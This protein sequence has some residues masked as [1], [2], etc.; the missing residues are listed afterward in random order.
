MRNVRKEVA[1]IEALGEAVPPVSAIEALRR[2]AV[3][4]FAARVGDNL[5]KLDDIIDAHLELA[6]EDAKSAKLV[7]DALGITGGGAGRSITHM[8]Q[9]V[10]M[11]R[12]GNEEGISELRRNI[13]LMLASRGAKRIDQI[14]DLMHVGYDRAAGAVA[15]HDWFCKEDGAWRLT[16]QGKSE[17]VQLLTE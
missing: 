16:P 15:E 12:P 4:R 7:F 5:E 14:A 3:A 17:S 9:A 10:L 2:N 8:Q 13:A 11:S 6:K 1:A